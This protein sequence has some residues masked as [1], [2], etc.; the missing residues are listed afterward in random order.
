M[1]SATIHRPPRGPASTALAANHSE[2]STVTS[3]T[4]DG[5]GK[6]AANWLTATAAV[7]PRAFATSVSRSTETP[8]SSRISIRMVVTVM[9]TRSAELISNSTKTN[10]IGISTITSASARR[11]RS[12]SSGG[13]GGAASACRTGTVMAGNTANATQLIARAIAVLCAIRATSNSG[14]T[15]SVAAK[16]G[17]TTAK[18]ITAKRTSA[19]APT[20]GSRAAA[21]STTAITTA[22]MAGKSRHT[23]IS[24][25]SA[26][27]IRVR[28]AS[29]P[30]AL[31]N[32]S[33]AAS[34]RASV[35]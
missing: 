17:R 14:T 34:L 31:P 21:N 35:R 30:S 28:S 1:T 10:R 19:A 26:S 15:G 22:S 9:I 12:L 16:I 32:G 3:I 33:G 24:T 18:V 4:A 6:I 13:G 2:T 23:R 25:H 11:L 8:V 29:S 5:T 27:G 7:P 20:P